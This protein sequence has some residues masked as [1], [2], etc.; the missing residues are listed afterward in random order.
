M[1][2]EIRLV[3]IRVSSHLAVMIEKVGVFLEFVSS[4]ELCLSLVG[5]FIGLILKNLDLSL[6]LSN[7]T[8][9]GN[10]SLVLKQKHQNRA[11]PIERH[12]VLTTSFSASSAI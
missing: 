2:D 5:Q 1:I 12:R 8:A 11:P 4:G 10:K 7:S 3:L 6:G 9:S